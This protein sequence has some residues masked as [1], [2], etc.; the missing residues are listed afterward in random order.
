MVPS[1]GVYLFKGMF[2]WFMTMQEKDTLARATEIQNEV[3]G[4]RGVVGRGDRKRP[5]LTGYSVGFLAT[6]YFS[7]F[8]LI[9]N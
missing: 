5:P 1:T 7:I 8:S 2:A 4:S 6:F 3:G 9:C